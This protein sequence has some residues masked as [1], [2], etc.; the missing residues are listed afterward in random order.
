MTLLLSRTYR[1]VRCFVFL[2]IPWII[3]CLSM[4]SA[5]AE[6]LASSTEPPP[7]TA[8]RQ[9]PSLFG[10]KT[11]VTIGLG[12]VGMPR[13]PGAKE[14]HVSVLPTLSVYRG[15]FFL[16]SLRGVGVEY[17]TDT[18]TY[19]SA[20]LGYDF[21]RTDRDS[22]WRPGSKRLAGMGEIEGSTIVSVLAAQQITSWLSVNGDADF[23]VGGQRGRGNRYRLGLEATLLDGERDEIRLGVN[24]HAGSRDYNRTWFGV[25]AAQSQRSRF[26]AFAPKSGMYAHSLTVDWIRDLDSHWSVLAGIDVMR[27]GDEAGRSPVVEK[28]TGVTGTLMINYTF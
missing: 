7:G 26:A 1:R 4:A 10:D 20:A 19:I 23:R 9:L 15:I 6:P 17:L 12:P 28:R 11:E 2:G 8:E 13:Y 5:H 27:F 21:G 14:S 22:D 24:A 3:A 16:D 25:S 18:G